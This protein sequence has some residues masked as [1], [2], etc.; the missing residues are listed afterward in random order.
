VWAG[1]RDF[2]HEQ[3]QFD[4]KTGKESGLGSGTIPQG[5]VVLGAR[6]AGNPNGNA[7]WNDLVRNNPTATSF[8]R[9]PDG[10]W[11]PFNGATLDTDGWNYQPYNYLV[12]PQTRFNL[13]TSG[14]RQLGGHVRAF[15]DAYYSKRTSSQTLAPSR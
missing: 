15:F 14:D 4:S 3:L 10:T 5:R 9:N 13:F 6:E 2:S 1:N 8:I 11:R 7:A 12:T